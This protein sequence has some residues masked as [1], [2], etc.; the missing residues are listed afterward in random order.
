VQ[1]GRAQRDVEVTG[2][3]EQ[4][5]AALPLALECVGEVLAAA[6]ADLDLGRD[7]LARDGVR[8]H[9]VLGGRVI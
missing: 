2:E 9:L 6:G 5:P 4:A 1:P 3:R 7:Q 8:E